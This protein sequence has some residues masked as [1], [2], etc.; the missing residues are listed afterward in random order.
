MVHTLS[1]RRFLLASTAAALASMSHI[2]GA[3]SLTSRPR[4]P[5]PQV[6]DGSTGEPI[7]LDIRTGS[8]SFMPGVRTPTLGLSQDYLGPTIRMRRGQEL[9][10]HYLNTL[11]EGG[12]IHGHG[13]HV[14]GRVDGGPQ[15][16]MPPGEG[17]QPKID[18][19]QPAAT[20]WY[21]SHAHGRTGYQTYHGLAGMMIIDDDVSDALPLPNRYGVDDLPVIIQD[22]TFDDQGRLLYSLFEAGEDGWFGDTVIINGAISPVATVPAGK[23]RLRLLNAANGRFYV[24]A[25]SDNRTFHKIATDGGFMEAPVPLKVMEMSP[26]E[27]CEIIVDMADG[28]PVEL[29]TIFEDDVDEEGEGTFTGTLAANDPDL[30][31]FSLALQVDLSLIPNTAPLPDNMVTIT[32]PDES[33]IKR[34]REFSL[35]ME[36]A[37]DAEGESGHDHSHAHAGHDHHAHMDMTINGATMDMNVTNE[38]V[39]LGEWERWR[40]RSD[41]GAHPFHVH[42]CSFLIEQMEGEVVPEAQMGWKDMIVL[43]DDDW[44]SFVVKFD[45][46]A[47]D[48]FPFMYHCHILE[49]EDRGMMGQFTVT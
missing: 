6:M 39:N 36:G 37:H 23:V 8:W 11:A 9:N 32:R 44:S 12:S 7:K 1:R 45:H 31:K 27:R 18:V 42:G 26:G 17:W 46:E 16:E 49:H 20:C 10:L 33:Q 2:R 38:R 5:I 13:L 47:T 25:F 21:H 28:A 34:T 3:K 30:S 48:D 15:L 14:P 19:V 41:V 24:I 22:K 40:I 4:L 29:L 35:L 43:D